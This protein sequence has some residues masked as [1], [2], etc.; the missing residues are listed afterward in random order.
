M[1]EGVRV[2]SL[3]HYLQGPAGAQYLADMGADVIKVEPIG[4]AYERRWS[5]ARV[6]VG[7]LSGFYLCANK[8]KRSICIDLKSPEGKAAFHKLVA[9][10][11]VVMENFRPGTLDRLGLGYD[12]LKSNKEDIIFASASG[13]GSD[14][15]YVGVARTGPFGSGAHWTDRCDGRPAARNPTG[16]GGWRGRR[17]ARRGPFCDGRSGRDH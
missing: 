10:A 14:G 17:S 8:N 6:F 13:Y 3:C 9:S 4:G 16:G 11:D 5:G 1:L 7:E 12:V 2:I 15:P